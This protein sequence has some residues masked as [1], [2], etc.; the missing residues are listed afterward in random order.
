[1]AR[2]DE[3]AYPRPR[4]MVMTTAETQ[5]L[6]GLGRTQTALMRLLLHNKSGL[7]VDRIAG[8][9]GVTRTAVN[10]HLASLERDGY[11]ER[12]DV[13]ATGG[14]PSRVFALSESGIHLF[15]KKY[16]LISLKTLEAL[17]SALGAEEARK[18]LESV[19]R[20]IGAGIGGEL[21]AQP[22]DA[23]MGAIAAAMQDFGFDAELEEEESAAEPTITAYNCIYHAL[24]RVHPDI[25]ALDIALL[26]EASG[27]D[28][29]HVACMAK[30]D[31]A[32]RFRFSARKQTKA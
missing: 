1:M 11:V 14:R 6:G 17:I 22:L 13:V 21:K 5:T 12:R 30:G 20:D 24:A 2:A 19:G 27:A 25:C 32:C 10:Q 16:D 8:A 23:R 28:V 7:T 9:I 18:V 26:R 4:E 3:A 15:P 29:D 31:N